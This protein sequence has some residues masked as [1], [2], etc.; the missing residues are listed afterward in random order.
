MKL[1]AL[2]EDLPILARSADAELEITGVS[3]DSRRTKP[4]DLFVAVSGYATDGHKFI[5]MALQRG[6]AAV[7]C[8]HSMPE[9]APWIRVRS[10]RAALA[11]LGVNW[12][13]A[14]AKSMQMI[15]V[16]GTNGKTSITCLV[17]EILEKSCGAMV[18]LIGTIRNM[19][20]EE[21]LE[22]ERTTPESFE[23]Q[24][25]LAQMRDAGCTHV[26]ME[27]SS[28]ALAL[29]R[30]AGLWFQAGIFTNL[31]RDHL[32]F[33]GTMEAYRKAKGLLFQ[34]CQTGIFNLDDGAGRQFAQT[35]PCQA[36]TFGETQGQ[37]QV[38][39]RE[40]RLYPDRVSFQVH[41]PQGSCP[42]TLPI[43]GRFT[44]YNALGV[45]ACCLALGLPMDQ[46]AGALARIP[47]VKGRVEV[48]PV[49][50]PYTVLIDYAHTPDALEKVLTAARDVTQ[51]RLLC[52][53][54]CGGDRDRT[55]RPVMGEI[56]A[57]LADLVILT[58]DNPRTEDPE[59]ILD[60]V[61]AGF[62][63]GF[64]AWVRQPDRRAAIRQ[65]LSMG[66]AGDVILLAGKGHE[67]EQEIG[68]QRVHLDE[69]EEIASFFQ[70]NTL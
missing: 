9:D 61:A 59:A 24:G 36:V 33:H 49:P 46:A 37:A 25:L 51:C 18:G 2:L 29:R 30:T 1:R 28:H 19:I 14:P 67:T 64:T 6:A 35:A 38:L 15:G 48:V 53:F 63:P 13:G 65:A 70:Q 7:L 27:V 68:T 47:G 23:L 8:E 66:R 60:Q 17:K 31:T 11:Q 57:A 40:I 44:V 45:L 10:A 69:R 62:P 56:A 39:A 43:P 52:L 58:S 12:Y 21:A 54:G 16:T 5:P 22:T 55:K 26:V 20:G 42:V 32:D 4:G 50:A 3:Y 34:Q 41:W